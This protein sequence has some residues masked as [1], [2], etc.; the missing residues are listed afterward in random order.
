MFHLKLAFWIVN[1][2]PSYQIPIFNNICYTHKCFVWVG[3]LWN[4]LKGLHFTSKCW[5]MEVLFVQ[6]GVW[7]RRKW[8]HANV[9]QNGKNPKGTWTS[10]RDGKEFKANFIWVSRVQEAPSEYRVDCSLVKIGRS[11]CDR[12]ILGE[13]WRRLGPG[14]CQQKFRGYVPQNSVTWDLTWLWAGC[15]T[16]FIHTYHHHHHHH[17]LQERLQI[18]AGSEKEWCV[19]FFQF[20]IPNEYEMPV[21]HPRANA[22]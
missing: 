7:G 19:S 14:R 18:S 20:M 17:H 9:L 5:G 15:G 21:G 13:K 22:K 6:L 11:R 1:T 16:D 4:L 10:V 2:Y 12:T 8:E 3:H